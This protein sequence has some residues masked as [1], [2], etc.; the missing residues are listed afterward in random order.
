MNSNQYSLPVFLASLALA[1]LACTISVGGPEYPAN[2]IPFSMEAL[3]S[4]E[5]QLTQAFDLGAESGSIKLQITEGQLTSYLIY[6]MQSQS[7]P[8]FDEPQVLLRDGQ[9]QIFGKIHHGIFLANMAITIN[10]G[11]DETG[12]PKI[13]VVSADFG[14]FPAPDGLDQAVNK[15]IS[16]AYT[17]SLGPVASGF[18]LES[19]SIGDGSMTLIGR[20]K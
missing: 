13:E 19:I 4:L 5:Q 7:N 10:L 2:P 18:R 17:G 20:I 1:N 15:M 6:K 9:M 12:L 3:E 11:V 14:P 8:P 16:E